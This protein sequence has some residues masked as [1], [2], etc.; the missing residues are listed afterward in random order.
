MSKKQRKPQKRNLI[1]ACEELIRSYNPITHSIDTHLLEKLGDVSQPVTKF[2]NFN[3][4]N[5]ADS[6]ELGPRGCFHPASGLRLS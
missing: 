6:L 4:F 5:L 1:S 3:P 2:S